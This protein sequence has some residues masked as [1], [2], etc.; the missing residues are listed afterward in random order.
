M[1]KYRNHIEDYGCT[2]FVTR[3]LTNTFYGHTPFIKEDED[4]SDRDNAIIGY[5]SADSEVTIQ[6]GVTSIEWHVFPHCNV[7]VIL[8]ERKM[9]WKKIRGSTPRLFWNT[10]VLRNCLRISHFTKLNSRLL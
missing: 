9:I 6:E 7:I 8:M 10:E 4:F 5:R 1:I 3:H 2:T